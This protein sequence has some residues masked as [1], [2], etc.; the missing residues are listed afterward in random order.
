MR[1]LQ[2]AEGFELLKPAQTQELLLPSWAAC[3]SQYWSGGTGRCLLPS[4]RALTTGLGNIH[5]L[6]PIIIY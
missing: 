6:R 1:F 4:A 3:T 5:F 2:R